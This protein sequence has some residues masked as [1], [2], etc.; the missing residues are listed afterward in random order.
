[1]KFLL[2]YKLRKCTHQNTSVGLTTTL[3]VCFD[4][5]S[6]LKTKWLAPWLWRT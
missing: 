6:T 2:V 1:M 4:C 5:G 3:K